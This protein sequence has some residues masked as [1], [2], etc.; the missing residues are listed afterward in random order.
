MKARSARRISLRT[1]SGRVSRVS[2]LRY[3][4]RGPRGFAG[5]ALFPVYVTGF[6]GQGDPAREDPRASQAIEQLVAIDA[7][8]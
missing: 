5:S 6:A 1:L 7:T 2:G 3:G 8:A 4:L